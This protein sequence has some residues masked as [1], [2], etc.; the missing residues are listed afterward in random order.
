M[1]LEVY[2]YVIAIVGGLFAGILN[3]L[4]GNGSA[5]TLTIL[6][7]LLQ[8]PGNLANGTNRVGIVIQTGRAIAFAPFP[9]QKLQRYYAMVRP[10]ALHRYARLMVF[11]F[12]L[13]FSLNIRATGS[14]VPY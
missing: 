14:H 7:E 8:L 9:L 3:T 10:C 2:H 6:T 12:H 1:E 11:L 13:S 5:I 4:A